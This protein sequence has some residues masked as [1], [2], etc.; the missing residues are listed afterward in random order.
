MEPVGTETV[1]EQ[2]SDTHDHRGRHVA[3]KIVKWLGIAVAVL[4][5]LVVLIVIGLNTAPGRS[6]AVKQINNL[7]LASGLDIDIDRIDGSLYGDLTI[8]GLTL[9]DP[10]GVF[11][12]SP[13]VRVDWSP[14]NF[15]T[16]NLLDVHALESPQVRLMRLPEL[17]PSEDQNA[18]LLPGFDIN[19]DKLNVQQLILEEP[20]AGKR[21]IA[22][23]AGSVAIKNQVAKLML[24]AKTLRQQG[25][26]GGDVVQVKLDAAPE[27]NRLAIDLDLS[28]PADGL[29]ASFTN[30]QQPIRAQLKGAGDWQRWD[31]KL[32]ANLGG[33]RIAAVDLAARDGTFRVR[34]DTNPG[35][36]MTG[37]T[38]ALLSPLTRIDLTTK[39]D[40]SRYDLKGTVSSDNFALAANGLIDLGKNEFDGF[41][42]DFLLNKPSTLAE[43][44]NGRGIRANL[45][46]DGD[47]RTPAVAYK[48]N[49]AA[50]GFN[51][52]VVERLVAEGAAR[53]DADRILIPVNA[54]A[55][56][57]TGLN[58]TA[59]ELLTN[60]RLSGDIAVDGP[61]ILSD[62]LRIRSDRLQGEAL[63]LADMSTGLYTG[64]L[65]GQLNN[66]R[67]ESVGIFNINTQADLKANNQGG[68][69]LGGKIRVRSTQIFNQSAKDF[70]GG[71]TLVSTDF[72]FG[73]DGV[74]RLRNLNVASPA[75]RLTGGSGSYSPDGQIAFSGQ[76]VSRQYGPLG[77]Q[78]TGTLTNPTAVLTADQPGFGIGLANFKARVKG[79]G[80]GY[81]V[82]ANGDTDYG[83]FDADLTVITGGALTID[84]A[85]A[86]FAGIAFDGRVRQ[87]AA[88]PFAGRLNANGSGI[89][90]VVQLAS[91]SGVQQ[92]VIDARANNARLPGK[93]NVSIGRA[94]IDATVTLYAQP[95][96][97]ADVQFANTNYGELSINAARAK[98]NYQGGNGTAKL[99][100]EGRN[101]VPFRIA[102]NADLKPD[103]W[104]VALNGRANSIDF[105]TKSPARIIP[106]NGNYRLQPVTILLSSG[107]LQ[108]AGNYGT[109]LE[110]QSRLNNVDLSIANTI[111]PGLG[112]GGKANG[113][114]DFSQPADGSFPR[115]DARLKI[116][117]FTRTSLSAVSTPIDI[118]FVGKLLPS[119]GDARA[120]LRQGSTVIG[121]MVATLTPL[122]PGNGSWTT[123]VLAAP[124][125]GGIRY[126]GPASTLF[127][128]AA[129]PDQTL[130]GAIGLAAD[131]GGR[132]QAPQLNG[133]VRANDL[134][135]ENEVY[136]TRLSQMKLAGTFSNDR[137]QL[138]TLR[139]VAGDGSVQGSGYVSLSAD[140]GF[141][142][143]LQLKLD[144]AR[145]ARSDNISSTATGQ[146]R[147]TNQPGSNARI[148][149]TI[150]LP[151][152][153][154]KI[155]RQGGP[156]VPVLTG[157]RRKPPLGRQKIT[158]DAEPGAGLPTVFD[159]AV[160]IKADDQIYIS[161]MG[162][163]SE[164]ATD[165]RIT[166]TTANPVIGGQVSLVRGTYGF[167]GNSFEL[168]EGLIT[169]SGGALTNP[170]IKIAA[171]S[172]VDGVTAI[173]NVTGR[174]QNPQ[175][176]FTSTPALPQDEIISRI[177]FG[178][179]VANLSAI[180][181]VQLASSLNSLRGGGGGFNPLGELQ[182][183]TG[184]DRL[185]ILGG[186][187]ATGRGTALAA[188]KYLTDDVYIEIITDAR[189]F[190]ATQL[191]VT[192]TPFLSVLSSFGS[193]GQSNVN[194]QYK[195]DY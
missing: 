98:V 64:A 40:N 28:A 174:A 88:G 118:N 194:V 178:S 17:I 80:A 137:F 73:S 16:R 69:T 19:V 122:P 90:G 35:L 114:L 150:E 123:R 109:A 183:A 179:S 136:G 72:A 172:D 132:V 154:Y 112:L 92:A 59:G 182:A 106:G 21:S 61:R 67:I 169:F 180:Q 74:A 79:G 110:L 5:V 41:K 147:I 18:P 134:T 189:G 27:Q 45:V 12:T 108:L 99:Y 54:S 116:D 107:S 31:G 186:D 81:A 66:Y 11:A 82:I 55:A 190:T 160:T 145:L 170:T 163:E 158:G 185:R 195:K 70:L 42:L 62:N 103:L 13:R 77:L 94:I 171:Q 124:L 146:I 57:I 153:R 144:D 156:Q 165:L 177:L 159:L 25:L 148:A 47:F 53:V 162:L 38:K 135:Y 14:L 56:R 39:V 187:E 51:D 29:V 78:L 117:R 119:G 113:S 95:S 96:V 24:N 166:G 26:A 3:L 129:V 71:N 176:A 102:G 43:N 155:I 34:G 168:T 33:D 65:Q 127:S 83:P 86:N 58:A 111:S 131:F 133:L 151:E 85:K 120:V 115:A 128:F 193:F 192:L 97:V 36:L 63:I 37:P 181:A 10:K 101:G 7:E 87:T 15:A 167:A 76:G 60:V 130:K 126:N 4:L 152:T 68:F 164:W 184:I 2:Y 46:L 48:L 8:V 188:G 142:L 23:L 89:N 157:V 173:L 100:A 9:R 138:D 104:R 91:V 139:A 52:I 121:R 30:L 141:P 75:F 105:K 125:G 50:L 1:T 44:L 149:G 161:G 20:V 175:I 84:I 22:S 191:E 140:K 93:Y 6:F 32:L 143:D 49:A